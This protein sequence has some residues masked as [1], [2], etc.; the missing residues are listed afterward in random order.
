MDRRSVILV[1]DDELRNR[2]L[3]RGFLSAFYDVVEAPSGAAAQEILRKTPVDLVL[4]DVMMP[5]QDGFETCRLIKAEPRAGFLPL[6][7]DH[8]GAFEPRKQRIQMAGA[9]PN[10]VPERRAG[11]KPPGKIVPVRRP[12][13]Q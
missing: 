4:L 2:A 10:D 8:A 7:H 3:M 5:E 6:P 12:G 1:V 11:C 13:H 9:E